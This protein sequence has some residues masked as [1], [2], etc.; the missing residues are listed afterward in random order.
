MQKICALLAFTLLLCS[1]CAW[2]EQDYPIASDSFTIDFSSVYNDNPAATPIAVDPIDKP[3][4]T[5]MPT[6]NFSY[7]IF[8]SAPLSISFAIPFTWLL[9]PD[10]NQ[11]TTLQFVEPQSEMMD[12]N[13]YQTRITIERVNIGV[14]QT[15]ADA[16]ARLETVLEDLESSFSSF[17]P[18]SIASATIGGAKGSYCYYKAEYI[19]PTSN[20]TYQMNGRI[21]I[22]ASGNYLYQVRL[23]APRAW[24]SYYENVFRRLRTTWKFL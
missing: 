3:T 18:G 11:S 6:P 7:R 20:K 23:T 14:S 2:A 1:A 21:T 8:E 19:D 10:T 5:P 16:R 12:V 17:V 13:G 24:Y 9:N 4:P 15:V 22:V